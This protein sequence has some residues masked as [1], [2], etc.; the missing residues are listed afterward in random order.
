M[1]TPVDQIKTMRQ[2]AEEIFRAAL[3]AVDPIEAVFRYVKLVDG[4][5]QIGE[6]RFEFKDYDRILVVGAGKAGAPMVKALE[7]YWAIAYRMVSLW[8][9]KDTACRCSTYEHMRRDILFPMNAE[10][11]VPR[12][13]CHW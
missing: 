9:R 13:F 11:E 3:K 8:S 12:I 7:D 4:G 1:T 5:L 2:Q 10:Y 6:R